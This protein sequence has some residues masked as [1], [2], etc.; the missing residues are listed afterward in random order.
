MRAVVLLAA[1]AALAGCVTDLPRHPLQERSFSRFVA[2]VCGSDGAN[3]FWPD[4]E[5]R[6]HVACD[7]PAGGVHVWWAP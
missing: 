3:D 5:G 7:G 4:S 2:R 1:A 6:I